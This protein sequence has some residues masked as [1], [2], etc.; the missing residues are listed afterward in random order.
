MQICIKN[1]PN[2]CF[3]VDICD[4]MMVPAVKLH[5]QD[6]DRQDVN[7]R[8]EEKDSVVLFCLLLTTLAALK[9]FFFHVRFYDKQ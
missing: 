3:V 8:L 7:E 6:R 9:K 1:I 2:L 4:H 5:R